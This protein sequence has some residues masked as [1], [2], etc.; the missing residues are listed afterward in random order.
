LT[1]SFFIR[2]LG[3]FSPKSALK[4]NRFRNLNLGLRPLK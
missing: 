4:K 3:S 1:L 2:P